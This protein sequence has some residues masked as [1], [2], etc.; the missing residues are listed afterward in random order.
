[1][2]TRRRYLVF[3]RLLEHIGFEPGRFQ[4]RWISGSEGAKFART[5]Q[6]ITENLSQ[7]GPNTRMRDDE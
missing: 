4:A 7:L 1:M 3:K 6:E 2:F 5:V